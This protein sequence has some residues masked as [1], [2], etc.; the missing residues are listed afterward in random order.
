[1]VV[2]A[3]LEWQGPAGFDD[4]VAITVACGRMGTKSFDLVFTATCEG[5]PA[6]V[7]TITYVSVVPGTHDSTEVPGEL[8]A[9]LQD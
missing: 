9:A 4:D 8:R 2:K 6:C 7:G 1:M 5:A 3:V